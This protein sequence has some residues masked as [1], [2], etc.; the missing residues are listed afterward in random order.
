MKC[1]ILFSLFFLV[2]P[3]ARRE[4]EGSKGTPLDPGRRSCTLLGVLPVNVFSCRK[5]PSW[6][7]KDP[8]MFYKRQSALITIFSL[9]LFGMLLASCGNAGSGTT[10][11]SGTTPTAAPTSAPTATPTTGT[12]GAVVKTAMATVDGKSVMILTDAKGMTL[13]YRKSDTATSV[14]SGACAQSWPPLIFSGSGS[15]TSEAQLP[16]ALSVSNN[17]NGAQ[18]TYQGHPL[19][20]FILDKS[21]GEMTGQGSNDV[22][23]VATTD[24][25]SAGSGGGT[26]TPTP[27]PGYGGY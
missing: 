13:Y 25:T 11:G 8:E 9:L 26:T 2:A 20:T 14:C 23:F 5:L 15:P 16:G 19:Y 7:G 6:K 1:T 18:V 3:A 17:T 4:E 10:T 24:L 27:T 21:P 22:W 12:S